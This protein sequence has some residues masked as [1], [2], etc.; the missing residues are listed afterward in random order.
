MRN[1]GRATW[2][3][4][5]ERW[6]LQYLAEHAG[7]SNFTASCIP[8]A[9]SFGHLSPN[10]VRDVSLEGFIDGELRRRD[11]N[12]KGFPYYVFAPHKTTSTTAPA[13]WEPLWRLVQSDFDGHP[14]AL[15]SES[16]AVSWVGGNTQ[17]GLGPPGSGSSPH[18]HTHAY[19]FLVFG[20]KRWYL[21]PP[22]SQTMSQTHPLDLDERPEP[23]PKPVLCDMA[24]GDAMYVP[25]DWGH[26]VL[27][28]EDSASVAR[29]FF[30]AA[31][32]P[33]FGRLLNIAARRR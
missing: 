9:K 7:S 21:Y 31:H 11:G 2:P 14:S 30:D 4:A 20:S 26:A 1:L 32:E 10:D 13:G 16:H 6:S 23:G 27:N 24:A 29:E 25:F 28:L 5:Y 8:Y 17:F 3:E 33:P 22:G 19:T 12:E 15:F 18:Y